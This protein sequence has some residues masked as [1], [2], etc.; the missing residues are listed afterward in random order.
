MTRGMHDCKIPMFLPSSCSA[1]LGC[2]VCCHPM[3]NPTPRFAP[4]AWRPKSGSSLRSRL[5]PSEGVTTTD[6]LWQCVDQRPLRWQH[7]REA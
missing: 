5:R 2:V 6:G 1:S 7:M 4:S 3:A